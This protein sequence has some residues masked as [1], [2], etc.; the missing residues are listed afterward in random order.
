MFKTKLRPINVDPP[1]YGVANAGMFKPNG[2][3]SGTVTTFTE[4]GKATP[5][6]I[7]KY[8]ETDFKDLLSSVSKDSSLYKSLAS[9]LPSTKTGSYNMGYDTAGDIQNFRILKT[10]TGYAVMQDIKGDANH[11]D[12]GDKIMFYDDKGNLV[13][14]KDQQNSATISEGSYDYSNTSGLLSQ[15]QDKY[16]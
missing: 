4:K 9:H 11:F 12:A 6:P 8:D 14:T 1:H 5:I 16:M 2:S 7:G 13:Q 15:I 10:E 3:S